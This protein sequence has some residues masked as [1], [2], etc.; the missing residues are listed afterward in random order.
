MTARELDSSPLVF[1]GDN[2][3][4]W[5]V[6]RRVDVSEGNFGPFKVA[7]WF[8]FFSFFSKLMLF[9]KTSCSAL[10]PQGSSVLHWN[11]RAVTSKIRCEDLKDVHIDKISQIIRKASIIKDS[12]SWDQGITLGPHRAFLPWVNS[13]VLTTQPSSTFLRGKK[14]DLFCKSDSYNMH[15]QKFSTSYI[16]INCS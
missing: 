4:P 8:W 9:W 10:C 15:I 7:G 12:I 5:T 13:V 16:N 1:H 6:P 3:G 11:N 14:C 2:S